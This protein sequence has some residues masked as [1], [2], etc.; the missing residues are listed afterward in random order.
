MYHVIGWMATCIQ[1]AVCHGCCF[2]FGFA[3]FS[4]ARTKTTILGGREVLQI[5]E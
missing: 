5:W 3:V 1:V 4:R 2:H